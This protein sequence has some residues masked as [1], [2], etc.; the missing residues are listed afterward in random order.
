MG[1]ALCSEI[2]EER[3]GDQP[4]AGD[5]RGRGQ[6]PSQPGPDRPTL[7]V[8]EHSGESSYLT[9]TASVTR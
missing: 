9:A 6:A 7:T 8:S 5:I 2:K 1:P 4:Q 3:G